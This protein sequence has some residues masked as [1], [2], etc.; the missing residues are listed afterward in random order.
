MRVDNLLLTY[1]L[2]YRVYLLA[3]LEHGLNLE[4]LVCVHARL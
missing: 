1:Y 4:H 2:Y 3:T